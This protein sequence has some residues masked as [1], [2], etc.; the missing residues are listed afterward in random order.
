METFLN[1]SRK[2][3]VLRKG[4][5]KKQQAGEGQG[6]ADM[7]LQC[8]GKNTLQ[9]RKIRKKTESTALADEG[10]RTEGYLSAAKSF[11]LDSLSPW[12]QVVSWSKML[13]RK[14]TNPP[15]AGGSQA[16]TLHICF[17]GAEQGS[18]GGGAWRA[19]VCVTVT[20]R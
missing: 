2:Q 14:R 8:A 6:C 17:L 4:D 13:W 12:I 11:Q 7:L 1:D 10:S 19:P 3:R 20:L 15:T 9:D 5:K 16:E 18:G